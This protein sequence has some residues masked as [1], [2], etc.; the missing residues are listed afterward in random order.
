M[1]LPITDNNPTR[2][3]PI[4]TIGLVLA[5]CAIFAW[6]LSLHDR[7][8]LL[9]VHSYGA[10]PEVVLGHAKLGRSLAHIPPWATLI[11]SMFLHGG[12]SHLLGNMLFLWI[13]GN[14]VEDAMGSV[15]FLVFYLLSG[16]AAAMTHVIAHP[17]S[18]E[19]MI[20]ASGAISGVLGAY[21]VLH[22]FANIRA[23][24]F[25]L[26]FVTWIDLPAW[27]FLGYWF[28]AQALNILNANHESNIAWWA[29][30]GGF[31]VGAALIPWFK[32]RD[33][34]LFDRGRSFRRY[35]TG[36]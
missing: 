2:S 29:H 17:D 22:P 25:L 4:V 12:W 23:L 5:C 32:Y 26:V 9:A 28:A 30:F 13:F 24:L 8:L 6:Q 31:L 27:I 16:V 36:W 18:V 3:V 14:N 11:T 20:G 19:P 33:V 10:I 15:R 34:R 21:F 35:S 7:S 1:L